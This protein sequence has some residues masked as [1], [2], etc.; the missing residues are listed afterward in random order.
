MYKFLLRYFPNGIANFIMALWYLF[1][2]IMNVYSGISVG[3]QGDFR[4]LG[5]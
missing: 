3:Q 4:Y 1:L 2:I 5:W